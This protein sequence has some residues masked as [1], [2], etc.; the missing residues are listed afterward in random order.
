MVD[1]KAELDAWGAA[2]ARMREQ[3]GRVIVGQQEVVEQLL[4]CLLAGGHALLEGIPGLGKTML[5]KTVADT[6][7]LSFSRIQ[8]TPDLMP[9]DIT[10]TNVIRFGSGSETS[11]RFEQGPIFGHFV[12]ADEINRATPKTQSAL[13]EAMQEQTVTVGAATHSLPA[14][15]FVL[16]TQNP[17]EQEGTYPLPEA[18]LDRFLLKILV[19][20]PTKEELKAIV[21][22]TTATEAPQAEPVADGPLL[23]AMQAGLRGMLVADEV[24][25]YA[26]SL[27]LATHPG[28]ER[29]PEAVNRYVRF[30]PGPRGA[31]AI[32]AVAKVRAFMAGR[33]H[34][35]R[36]DVAAVALP[37]L[38]HR[39][40]LNFEGQ[41]MGISA[42]SI[43]QAAIA[44]LEEAR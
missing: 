19:T 24:L 21:S 14:P 32:I 6:V 8:F 17:L 36:Q 28:G 40:L 4:W 16:A 42:D 39:V 15:F 35:S 9:A 38:R 13:L 44:A 25:D 3:I 41:A 2:V 29:A 22:R 10:G 31:Q 20:F 34:V 7:D 27:L 43:V 37:A 26:V 18:Q 12:L 23:L 33:Y 5:V 30:G 11:H 1:S